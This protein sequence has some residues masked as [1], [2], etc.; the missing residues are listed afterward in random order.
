M[1]AQQSEWISKAEDIAD[2]VCCSFLKVFL[3]RNWILHAW[4]TR[5]KLCKNMAFRVI[6]PDCNLSSM[7]FVFGFL[8]PAKILV[9]TFGWLQCMHV[10]PADTPFQDHV[11]YDVGIVG[12]LNSC[13]HSSDTPVRTLANIVFLIVGKN[14]L[15]RVTI[16]FMCS[17]QTCL[18]EKICKLQYI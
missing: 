8:Y 7:P 9:R 15:K 4:S 5:V 11:R 2:K 12:C 14:Y 3:I 13:L 1:S 16:L 10:W 18:F 6:L 17:I